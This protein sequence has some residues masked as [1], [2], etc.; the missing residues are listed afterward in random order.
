MKTQYFV[1]YTPTDWERIYVNQTE[2]SVRK[3]VLAL[4]GFYNTCREESIP[5]EKEFVLACA[6]CPGQVVAAHFDCLE[7][8]FKAEVVKSFAIRVADPNV[9][10]RKRA[11]DDDGEP[12]VSNKKRC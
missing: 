4:Q 5:F 2:A 9:A 7:P 11:R 1:K 6:N 3:H 10:Q 8:G 12:E